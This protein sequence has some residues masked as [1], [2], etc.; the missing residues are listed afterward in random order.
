MLPVQIC[1]RGNSQIMPSDAEGLRGESDSGILLEL[2]R[3]LSEK[4]LKGLSKRR[5]PSR[6]KVLAHKFN[7]LALP[8]S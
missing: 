7:F 3:Y 2:R 4:E 5:P 1:V 8:F 6:L